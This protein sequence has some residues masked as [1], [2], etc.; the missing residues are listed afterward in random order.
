MKYYLHETPGRLRIKI[1]GLRGNHQAIHILQDEL[2]AFHGVQDVTVNA[3]TGSVIILRDPEIARTWTILSLLQSLGYI[4]ERMV[5][6]T[7]AGSDAALSKVGTFLG[8]AIFGMAVERAL[9]PTGLS[10]LAALI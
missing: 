2:A 3:V 7:D 9:A 8:K 5:P 1:P 10:F 4:D 6:A